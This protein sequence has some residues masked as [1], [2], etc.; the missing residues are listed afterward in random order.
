MTAEV[1]NFYRVFFTSANALGGNVMGLPVEQQRFDSHTKKYV[2]D[3][4]AL[5][6][7]A[8]YDLTDA[9]KLT[10]GLRYTEEEKE[11]ND[12]TMMLNFISSVDDPF[13]QRSNS[14]EETTGKLGLDHQLSEDSLLYASFSRGYKG[15]G[16]N[17]PGLTGSTV[18]DPEYV[19]AFEV[20]L[21]NRWLDDTL[22]ANFSV[23][24]YDYEGLQV[25]KLVSNTAVNENVDSKMS[26]LE[27]EFVFAPNQNWRFGLNL[28]WLNAEIKEFSSIDPSDPAQTGSSEGV[29][30]IA[31]SNYV[32]AAYAPGQPSFLLPELAGSPLANVPFTE[33]MPVDVEGNQLPNSP[34]FSVNF[35]VQ[36]SHEVAGGYEMAY[37]FQYYWQDEYY[38]RIFNTERDRIDAWKTMDAQVTLRA[39]DDKWLLEAWVKNIADED[40]ITGLYTTDATSGLFTNSFLMDPRTFG[41]TA[42]YNF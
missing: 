6:G 20:G 11:V 23:F 39:P 42:A 37:R 15:G 32:L 16:F 29:I 1:E 40:H 10:L 34:E 30:S 38:A 35:N 2:V 8:Y 41:I 7:E 3:S 28:A 31:G 18:F 14:W 9:T 12:R 17:P 13:L 19:N 33:G 21:K 26:G 25:S 27:G 22:Q 24:T 5:F 36:Y 4:T